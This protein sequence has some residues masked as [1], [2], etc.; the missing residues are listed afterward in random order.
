[1]QSSETGTTLTSSFVTEKLK[2]SDTY[3]VKILN[4][5]G[6]PLKTQQTKQLPL[7]IQTHNLP[8]GKYIIQV[9]SNGK[10]WNKQLLIKH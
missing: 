2:K 4:E 6:T 8:N 5:Q 3:V 7:N 1:L 9:V 10:T